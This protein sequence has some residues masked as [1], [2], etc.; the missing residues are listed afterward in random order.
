M[1]K[2]L[3]TLSIFI[4][5]AFVFAQSENPAKPNWN[6][7]HTT[8]EAYALMDGWSK[9]YPNPGGFRGPENSVVDG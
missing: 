1:K 3:P 2:L 7:L 9:A 4:S 8:A 5:S 6:K